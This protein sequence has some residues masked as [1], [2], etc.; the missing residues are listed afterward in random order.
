[1]K[2]LKV[3]TSHDQ[4]GNAGK[5][6]GSWLEQLA[7]PFYAFREAGAE[8]TLASPKGGQPPLDPASNAPNSQTED[9]RRFEAD[10]YA[11]AQLAKTARLDSVRQENFDTVFYPQW[12]WPFVGSHQRSD[13]DQADRLLPRG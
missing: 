6:T 12:P 4:L 5:K 13:L 10:S 3:L 11:V 2:V 1:M 7:A 8:I 9:T